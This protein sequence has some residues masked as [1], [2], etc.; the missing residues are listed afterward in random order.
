PLN[1]RDVTVEALSLSPS[2]KK[3]G[4]EILAR[5]DS[6]SL[7]AFAKDFGTYP[8]VIGVPGSQEG[9]PGYLGGGL[10]GFFADNLPESFD[11]LQWTDR[12]YLSISMKVPP[13]AP[14]ATGKGIEI[15]LPAA[16]PG[17]SATPST[18]TPIPAPTPGV[19][20]VEILNGCGITNA[21]D[22]VARRVKGPG[23]VIT[24]TGNAD[25]FRYPKTIVRSC[26][27][28]PVAL[29]E[30]VERLGLPKDA[31]QEIPS[32]SSSVDVVVIVGKD[33]RKLR[34]QFRERNRH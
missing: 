18:S 9:W 33:Y 7:A 27:G 1:V 29:E 3:E 25:N 34:E 20:R 19:L 11:N 13:P 26:A 16:T 21:A 28:T 10:K 22:W 31:I 32:L 24:D 15:V 8:A 6:Q 14:F 12:L 17:T 4:G 2:Q 23:I 30:A 5:K